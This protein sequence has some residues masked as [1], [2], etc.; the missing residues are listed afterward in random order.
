MSR[1]TRGLR[2]IVDRDVVRVRVETYVSACSYS[3]YRPEPIHLAL[4]LSAHIT[5]AITRVLIHAC[6]QC[7]YHVYIAA[8]FPVVTSHQLRPGRPIQCYLLSHFV[9]SPCTVELPSSDM[10]SPL[11]PPE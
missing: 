5:H 9:L 3:P 7:S 2:G 10:D 1:D 4:S 11:L 8:V 6:A